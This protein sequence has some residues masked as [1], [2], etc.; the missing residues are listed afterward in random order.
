MGSVQLRGFGW[1]HAGRKRWA[2]RDLDLRIERG[3]R[4]LLLGPSGAGK[5][6]LLAALA[7]LLPEDSGEQEGT[8]EIDGLD[9][10]KA[11]ER[12]GIVFQDPE[13]QL[14]MARCGDDVAFGLENRGVP[15][16]EI[17]PRVDEALHRVGFPYR[18]D[19]PTAALSG[20]EQQRLALAGALALRPELLL[21]DE[22]TANLDLAGATQV[23]RAVADALDADTTVILVEH[24]VA[25]ALP[26]VD[27]VVVVEAGGGVRADG[28]PEAVFAAHGDALAAEGVWVPG[29]P[30]PPR[31]AAGPAGD[32]LLT[33]DR[34]GLPPRLAPTDLRVRAGEALAVLGPNGAGKSTLALLLGGLLR[35]G[36]GGVTASAELAGRD[37][38]TPPH[39]WRAPALARRIGSVFQDPEHQFV[40]GTVRDELALGPRRTGTPEPAVLATVDALLERLGLAALAG[41]NPYTLSGGE[42]RRLSVATALATAPRLLICDEPT[43]GQDRR[44]WRELVDL[45]AGLRDAGHG[46]VAV[47]HDADFVAALADRTVT[48]ERRP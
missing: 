43:F 18:R 9:P 11:R 28:T 36:T 27:R 35:P 39:R 23:R 38:R 26:L 40:T 17:W 5:S 45:L 41:A 46:I 6:T 3:E 13:S 30:V 24:R 8:V 47:T 29:H 7:G 25:E 19:R 20:G 14:V 12:V 1:R 32:L 48:L 16:E 44:T 34:L 33:A 42:A 4:V 21:L 2:V 10:R 31:R 15:A 22:P 37:A